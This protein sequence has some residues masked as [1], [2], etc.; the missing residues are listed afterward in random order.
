MYKNKAQGLRWE[1]TGE[2][3]REGMVYGRGFGGIL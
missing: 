1:E 3:G 2:A